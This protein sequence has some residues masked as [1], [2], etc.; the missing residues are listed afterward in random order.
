MATALTRASLYAKVSWLYQNTLDIGNAKDEQSFVKNIPFTDGE[1]ANQA[2]GVWRDDR[3]IA[4]STEDALDFYGSA[5]QD[6]FGNNISAKSIKGVYIE[7]TGTVS[8]TWGGNAAE[9]PYFA[10]VNDKLTIPAGSYNLWACPTAA[11]I[12]VTATTGDIL[13][14]T[15]TSGSVIATYR[16]AVFYTK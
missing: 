4:T 1:G 6:A 9:I 8:I 13:S 10:A 16:I 15:N 12:A 11:G 14:V 5:L 2:E 7:N 3:S